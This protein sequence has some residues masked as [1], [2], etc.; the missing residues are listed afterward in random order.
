MIDEIAG[1]QRALTK[2][3]FAF[4]NVPDLGKVMPVRWKTGARGMV[5][6]AAV[7]R[8]RVAFGWMDHH[9]RHIAEPAELTWM[10]VGSRH[11]G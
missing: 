10:F 7:G 1:A 11:F 6:R 9:P 5:D 8:G 3:A 4:Q 2:T